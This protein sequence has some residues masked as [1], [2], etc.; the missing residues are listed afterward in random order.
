MIDKN[1]SL[2]HKKVLITGVAGFIGANLAVSLLR[3]VDNIQIIGIDNLND[4]YDVS[5]KEYRLKQIIS[6]AGKTSGT[7]TFIK[8]DIAEKETVFGLFQQYCPDIVV[9]L[10]AQAGVRYSI[11][12]PD[13]YI[14]SN[15]IGFY[16]ILEACRH[17]Q[18]KTKGGV[19]HLVYALKNHGQAFFEENTG[20]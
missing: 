11:I 7:F 6:E 16:H 2:E 12:N 18:D 19:E 8:G 15:L 17:S 1:V 20:L 3:T 4:Y 5:L 14:K 10:A 9:N 13:A